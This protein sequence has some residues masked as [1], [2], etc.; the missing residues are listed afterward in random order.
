MLTDPQYAYL[1]LDIPF[2][3]VWLLLWFM[4]KTT[5]R[6]QI[7]MSLLFLPLGTFGEVLYFKDY[8]LPESILSFSAFGLHVLIED[9]I[10]SFAIA[11]SAAVIYEVIQ[12]MIPG[13]PCIKKAFHPLL[14]LTV[15]AVVV[16]GLFYLG[17]NSIFA[18]SIGFFVLALLLLLRRHDLL[19]D[20]I[21]SGVGLTVIMFVSY[22]LLY[23]V[24]FADPESL[25]AQM[26]MLHGTPLDLRFWGIPLTEM[27]WGFSFGMIVGPLYE[28]VKSLYLKRI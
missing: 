18:T 28:S 9:L 24:V 20:S 14:F 22:M 11:G 5:R 7:I 13:R 19:E 2:V 12:K 8:W 26:W 3:L 17:V 16:L 6:E 25:L 1:I 15:F 4:S 21:V 10:F 23:Y 27:I